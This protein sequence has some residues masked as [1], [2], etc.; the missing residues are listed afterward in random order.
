MAY[1][2]SQLTIDEAI[3]NKPSRMVMNTLSDH[4]RYL[5]ITAELHALSAGICELEAA[6]SSGMSIVELKRLMEESGAWEFCIG[7]HKR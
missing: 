1:K 6:K 4:V 3:E 2:E 7:R 5:L